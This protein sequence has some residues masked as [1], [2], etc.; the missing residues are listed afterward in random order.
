MSNSFNKFGRGLHSSSKKKKNG[1]ANGRGYEGYV[2]HPHPTPQ[3]KMLQPA[4]VFPTKSDVTIVLLLESSSGKS[5]N[6]EI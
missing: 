2:P 3:K 6:I 1:N 5:T 4:W